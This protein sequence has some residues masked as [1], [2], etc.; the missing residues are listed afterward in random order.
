MGKSRFV[1]L[2]NGHVDNISSS[3]LTG[4]LP[5]NNSDWSPEKI[6]KVGGRVVHCL[7][8]IVVKLAGL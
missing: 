3:G 6:E 7:A 5:V 1:P 2:T 4:E 8:S